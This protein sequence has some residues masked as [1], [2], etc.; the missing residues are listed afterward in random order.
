[1]VEKPEQG[2]VMGVCFIVIALMWAFTDVFGGIL[3]SIDTLLPL[4][5]APVGILLA[6][7]LLHFRSVSVLRYFRDSFII[8]AIML[9][10]K[11]SLTSQ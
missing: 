11:G 6:I 9:Y 5:V 2:K 7:V 1:M 3:M 10:Q 8:G 4:V